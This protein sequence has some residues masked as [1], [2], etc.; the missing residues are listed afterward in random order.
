MKDL[1]VSKQRGPFYIFMFIFYVYVYVFFISSRE[2]GS[3]SFVVKVWNPADPLLLAPPEIEFLLNRAL[4]YLV[5]CIE[6]LLSGQS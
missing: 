2:S 3:A 5:P 4:T 1:Q 6:P